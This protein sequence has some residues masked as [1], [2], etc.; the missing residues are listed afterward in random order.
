MKKAA[1]P[2]TMDRASIAAYDFPSFRTVRPIVANATDGAAPRSPAKLFG[3]RASASV[4]K[5]E[6]TNPPTRNRT[7]TS[8]VISDQQ[9]QRIEAMAYPWCF[10]SV[11]SGGLTILYAMRL[12]VFTSSPL[13]LTA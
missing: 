6:T 2:R 3:L 9:R 5:T 12:R 7:T 1:A 4:A 11:Y 8:I 13:S 10:A